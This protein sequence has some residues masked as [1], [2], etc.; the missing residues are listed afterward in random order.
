LYT[1]RNKELIIA[2][3]LHLKFKLNWETRKILLQAIWRT[4]WELDQAK[5]LQMISNKLLIL[6]MIFLNFHKEILHF[7]EELQK[8]LKSNNYNIKML[9]N[10]LNNY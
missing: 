8:F 4:Y 10:Y 5:I 6:K 2:A 7:K 1:A 3:C 9:N